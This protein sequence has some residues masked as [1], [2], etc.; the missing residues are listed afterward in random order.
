M[1][2]TQD[3]RMTSLSSSVVSGVRGWFLRHALIFKVCGVALLGLLLL[4]PLGMVQSTLGERQGRFAEAVASITQ[5]WGGTQRIAGPVLVVP[6][7]YK[8]DAMEMRL[9]DGRRTDVRIDREQKGEAFFLPEELM[10]D[11]QVTPSMRK[12]GIYE[13]PVYAAKLGISGKFAPPDFGFLNLRGLEPQWSQARV[14]FV[15]S[16]LRGTQENLG[17]KWGEGAVPL[18][19]G[20]R[21]GGM[22]AGVHAPVALKAGEARDFGLELT[23]NGSDGLRFLPLGRQTVVKLASTWADPSFGGAYLPT[24]RD[25]G[26]EGFSAAWRVSYY[27]RSFPQQWAEGGEGQ[28]S[29]QKIE[30]SAFGVNLMQPVNAYRTGERAIKYG[31]LFITLVFTTFFLFEAVCRVRLNALNYLLVGAALCLFYLGLVALAEFLTFGLAYALAAGAST[32]L[33]AL[34]A[35]KILGGG[36]RA[37]LVGGML[38]GV[39]GYLY[40]VLQMEDFSLLAGTGALFAVLA[41]VMWATRN[42]TGEERVES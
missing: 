36:G 19:P 2:G 10:V 18:Q 35:K 8:V 22:G 27:G 34:Y 31:V 40:F 39:Y 16:D 4:I 6:Y 28:P 14:C 26:P 21:F 13:T 7:T 5:I 11:G 23:L 3:G 20:A 38:G 1:R 30:E 29:V 9:I 37:W 25:V 12:R 42:L 24:E 41:A 17:L 33:I 32:L 15:I